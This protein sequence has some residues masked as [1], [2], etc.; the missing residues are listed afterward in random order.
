LDSPPR[1]ASDSKRRSLT[2]KQ[3]MHEFQ[4][5][6]SYPVGHGFTEKM[7]RE[8]FAC[9]HFHPR[10]DVPIKI[11]VLDDTD[12]VDG[13]AAAA[14][15]SKRYNWLINELDAG[16][17]AGELMIICAHIPLRPYAIPQ[18]PPPATPPASNPLYPLWSL[19]ASPVAEDVL[20]TK[21]HTYKNLILWVSGHVHRNAITPQ[22][23]RADEPERLEHSFWEVETPSLRDFPQQ[24]RRFEIVRNS[25]KTISIFALDVDPALAEPLPGQSPTPAWKSR[26]YAIA[27]DQL[28]GNPINEGP[29]VDP[30]TGVYNAELIKQVSTDMQNKL[31]LIVP[32][33]HSCAIKPPST[34]GGTVVTLINS[35]SGSTPTHYMASQS[36]DFIAAT[37]LPYSKKPSF[38]L[39]SP[40]GNKTLYFKVKDASGTES[41]V[42]HRHLV[43][44]K[45][46]LTYSN[47]SDF[48]KRG[49]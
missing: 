16:E 8:E 9:Y 25:N 24:L 45:G 22:L 46:L 12:K 5:T 28:F 49:W 30:S 41:E 47:D 3:W 14:L 26:S 15:D 37:W 19:F 35:I 33:V 7:I 17:A 34:R 10:E 39:D 1:I 18:N 29:N 20:L 31:A 4:Q 43:Y 11:I 42:I 21:L 48:G 13:G 2:V 40:T 32:H 23:A 38:T 44:R 36:P 6:S 27:T